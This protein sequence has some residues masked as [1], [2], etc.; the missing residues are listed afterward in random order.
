MNLLH[1]KVLSIIEI[2]EI[3]DVAYYTKNIDYI[4]NEALR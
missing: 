1:D 4:F 2:K 3:F